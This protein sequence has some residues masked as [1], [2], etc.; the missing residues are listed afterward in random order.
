MFQVR[1]DSGNRHRHRN[2]VDEK[3]SFR[4]SPTFRVRDLDGQTN[5][6]VP[7]VKILGP[8][9]KV[10]PPISKSPTVSGPG[11]TIFVARRS[12]GETSNR[13]FCVCTAAVL[14]C[15]AG[16]PGAIVHLEMGCVGAVGVAVGTRNISNVPN[17]HCVNQESISK[18]NGQTHQACHQA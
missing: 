17:S 7:I 9:V 13:P 16:T 10:P 14:R 12:P 6:K 2:D 4:L 11:G 3:I 18:C 8:T 5:P 1:G 15:S